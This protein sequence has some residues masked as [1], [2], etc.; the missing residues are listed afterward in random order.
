MS[1]KTTKKKIQAL[2]GENEK[3]RFHLLP[4]FRKWTESKEVNGFEANKLSIDK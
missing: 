3:I 2:K 1:Q 4:K